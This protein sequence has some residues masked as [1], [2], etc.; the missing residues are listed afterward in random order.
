MAESECKPEK[1]PCGDRG[2]SWFDWANSFFTRICN[3]IAWAGAIFVNTRKA[4]YGKLALIPAHAG[5]NSGAARTVTVPAGAISIQACIDNEYGSVHRLTVVVGGVDV[6]LPTG[7]DF[8]LPPI[9]PVFSADASGNNCYEGYGYYPQ[10][11]FKYPAAC[12][13]F[14]TAIYRGQTQTIVVANT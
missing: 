1:S 13:G 9:T 2:L 8:V 6:L 10:Y 5:L 11:V 3:L 12:R 4:P 7:V 14:I